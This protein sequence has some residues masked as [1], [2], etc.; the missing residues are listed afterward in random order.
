MEK[1]IP[2]AKAVKV[3][4]WATPSVE[5]PD[6]EPTPAKTK[7]KPLPALK[8]TYKPTPAPIPQEEE[9]QPKKVSETGKVTVPVP[10]ETPAPS[11]NGDK[12][13]GMTNDVP[14]VPSAA[15][16]GE[17]PK[18]VVSEEEQ[19]NDTRAR[20]REIKAVA[21][22]DKEVKAL[23]DKSDAASD[24]DQVAAEKA[25]YKALFRKMRALDP[26]LTDHIDRMEKAMMK[27][28]DGGGAGE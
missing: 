13:A 27:K 15:P 11:D 26:T 28:L 21:L 19:D 3:K 23:K 5:V 22:D 4:K 2:V 7:T 6:E 1:A 14:F 12:P 16:E 17:K 9:T 24:A 8:G 10:S 18:P 25:Y 20:Y